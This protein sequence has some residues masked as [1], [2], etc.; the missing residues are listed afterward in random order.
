MATEPRKRHPVGL[1]D[2]DAKRVFTAAQQD[3]DRRGGSF[4][5]S[6]LILYAAAKAG[7]GF[8]EVLLEAMGCN[9]DQLTEAVESEWSARTRY[10]QDQ[11]ATL[12]NEAFQTV[13]AGMQPGTDLHLSALLAAML[14]YPNA[15]A[16]RLATRV[17]IEP[18]L[19][20]ERLT[21]A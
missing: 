9:L 5:I 14:S 13:A 4:L 6:G 7:E 16:S 3:A 1:F 11:P 20:A 12:V 15:M 17:G 2:A 19:L 10:R 8:S 21:E 18:L